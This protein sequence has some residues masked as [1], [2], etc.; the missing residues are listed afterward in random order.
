M[1][2]FWSLLCILYSF[3]LSLEYFNFCFWRVS[4]SFIGFVLEIGVFICVGLDRC[5]CFVF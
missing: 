1:L 4:L 5:F 3:C 2:D